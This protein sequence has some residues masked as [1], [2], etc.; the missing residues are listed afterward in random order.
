MTMHD[1]A[2]KN[3]KLFIEKY[4]TIPNPKVLDVGSMDVNGTI[5]D[6]FP[7]GTRYVGADIETGPNV[8]TVIF[9]D[10]INLPANTFDYVVSSSCFEH[11]DFFWITF[12]EM[13]RVCKIGGYIYVNAPSS[14]P[15]HPYPVDNWRFYPDA[16]QALVDYARR[17]GFDCELVECF[18]HPEGEF[19]DFVMIV[20]KNGNDIL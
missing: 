10:K 8:D 19:K 7:G 5:R 18:I 15:Y 20:K 17:V 16:G 14:G 11:S 13:V 3:A 1:T 9:R 6:L 2:L 4:V 12:V